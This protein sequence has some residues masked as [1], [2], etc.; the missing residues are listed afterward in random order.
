MKLYEF[1]DRGPTYD[2]VRYEMEVNYKP[3][4][5]NNKETITLKA[6]GVYTAIDSNIYRCVVKGEYTNTSQ[7]K[8]NVKFALVIEEFKDTDYNSS[9]FTTIFFN[10]RQQLLSLIQAFF[11]GYVQVNQ[12]KAIT[13]KKAPL[14]LL[15]QDY[16]DSFINDG[17]SSEENI[18]E[19][20]VYEQPIIILNTKPSG[21]PKGSI[22]KPKR[23]PTKKKAVAKKVSP[24]S[25]IVDG[26]TNE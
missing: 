8:I 26:D 14:N 22:A 25:I 9:Y 16:D 13:V 18:E 2:V 21:R 6:F 1:K 5:V 17:I 23:K 3:Y 20:E 24:K 12:E 15:P 7:N 19:D 10:N 11:G 4:E